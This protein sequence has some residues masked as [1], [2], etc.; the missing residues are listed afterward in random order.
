MVW[1]K[2]IRTASLAQT[3]PGRVRSCWAAFGAAKLAILKCGKLEGLLGEG[4]K[5]REDIRPAK[6]PV[7]RRCDVACANS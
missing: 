5:G 6:R 7:F 4:P 1:R 3:P 2:A